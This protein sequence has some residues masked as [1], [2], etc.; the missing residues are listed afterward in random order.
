MNFTVQRERSMAGLQ[1]TSLAICTRA[2][3]L[4]ELLV[5]MTLLFLVLGLAYT[6]MYRS[7]DASTALRRNANDISQTLKTGEL[8]R[9]DV[10][11]AV[12][13]IH[14]EKS[15]QEI[16]LHV[17]RKQ[18]EVDYI[19]ATN[20]VSRR[21]GRG[22]W[23]TVLDHVKNCAFVDDQREKVKAW[24]WELELQ[25]SRKRITRVRP[26][27]TFIAVPSSTSAQ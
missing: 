12:R 9:D 20:V 26:L 27:F 5:Y 25:P 4:I 1:H 7:M 18:T 8:W 14:L 6:A 15:G 21:V 3:T 16:I 10:R 13:P 11:D 2:F 24:R 19:F 23:S 22:E 17:P